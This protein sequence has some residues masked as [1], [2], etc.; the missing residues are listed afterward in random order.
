[1]GWTP[2]A[3]VDGAA[4]DVGKSRVLLPFEQGLGAVDHDQQS[5]GQQHYICAPI[6]TN[7]IAMAMHMK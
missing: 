6:R 3:R 2:A 7:T 5:A 1:V 4:A